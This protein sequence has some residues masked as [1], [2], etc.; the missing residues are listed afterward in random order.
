MTRK[1]LATVLKEKTHF[2][3]S[4]NAE[5]VDVFFEAMVGALERGEKIKIPGFGNLTVR[6]K[7]ARM[8]KNPKTGETMQIS[9]RRVVTFKPSPVLRETLNREG[10]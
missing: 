3:E 6:E 2:P 9:A 1:E 7:R 5:F 4:Q 8:G 10:K